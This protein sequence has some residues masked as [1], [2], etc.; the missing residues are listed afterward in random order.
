[1]I[2]E[3]DDRDD[4]LMHETLRMKREVRIRKKS[5]FTNRKNPLCREKNGEQGCRCRVR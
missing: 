4:T 3:T 1:M 5:T 2:E